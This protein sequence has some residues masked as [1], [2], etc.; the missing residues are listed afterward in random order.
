MKLLYSCQVFKCKSKVCQWRR[1]IHGIKIRFKT[2]VAHWTWA[3][4]FNWNAADAF[5]C[6][7]SVRSF[8]HCNAAPF[9]YELQALAP[10]LIRSFFYWFIHFKIN[11]E[12][13]RKK[14]WIFVLPKL[15]KLSIIIRRS[16]RMFKCS[17]RTKNHWNHRL[18]SLMLI[19]YFIPKVEPH[20]NHSHKNSIELSNEWFIYD[21]HTIF[22][23]NFNTSNSNFF[24][25]IA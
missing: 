25:F 22:G 7:S 14:L 11:H 13:E 24:I 8:I 2:F 10:T 16:I 12:N 5:V 4:A 9:V 1:R 21:C 17:L 3:W 18:Q 15:L 20:T 23:D 19:E 6:H